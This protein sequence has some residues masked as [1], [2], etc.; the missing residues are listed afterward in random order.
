MITIARISSVVVG[1]V[2]YAFLSATFFEFRGGWI[3]L[4]GAFIAFFLVRLFLLSSTGYKHAAMMVSLGRGVSVM[5]GITAL[6]IQYQLKKNWLYFI[7]TGLLVMLVVRFA[8]AGLEG[9]SLRRSLKEE[10]RGTIDVTLEEVLTQTE[11]KP[12]PQRTPGGGQEPPPPPEATTIEAP[13]PNTHPNG[14]IPTGSS[15]RFPDFT[16]VGRVNVG[17]VIAI[18][19]D[20]SLVVQTPDGNHHDIPKTAAQVETLAPLPP[21]PRSATEIQRTEGIGAVEAIR[22]AKAERDAYQQQTGVVS[23]DNPVDDH[24]AMANDPR[25]PLEIQQELDG[26]VPPPAPVD[27]NAP[28]PRPL[29]AIEQAAG[30]VAAPTPAQAAAGNHRMGHIR[31]GG[32]AATIKMPLGSERT[33]VSADGTPWS[34]T[35]GADYGYIRGTKGAAGDHVHA[36]FGPEAARANPPPVWML[37]QIEPASG[38]FDEHKAMIGFPNR[39]AALTAYHA[40]FSDGSAA[41][42][43]GAIT[44][45]PWQ[46]FRAWVASGN[47]KQPVAY[48]PPPS[49]DQ[50]AAAQGAADTERHKQA[51]TAI[52][53]VLATQN[54]L[55]LTRAQVNEAAVEH[56]AG[57]TPAEAILKVAHRHMIKA[58]VNAGAT[59]HVEQP[60]TESTADQTGPQPGG[61]PGRPA[62]GPGTGHQPNPL[63]PDPSLG[64]SEFAPDVQPD[65]RIVRVEVPTLLKPAPEAHGVGGEPPITPTTQTIETPRSGSYRQ[66]AIPVGS[67][68]M[69]Y[70]FTQASEFAPGTVVGIKDDWLIVDQGD[71]EQHEVPLSPYT[72][73]VIQLAPSPPPP[74]SATTIM[75]DDGIGGLWA[76][77]KA[78]TERDAYTAATGVVIPDNAVDDAKAMLNDP[79]TEA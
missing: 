11:T 71:G 32:L 18:A 23:P 20:G 43:I 24:E 16:Q 31:V 51:L 58:I 10:M 57:L 37:D 25:S 41:S 30:N 47:T 74:R 52:A 15:V 35:M 14:V 77:Q 21:P 70:D 50:Q 13:A 72:V 2:V 39:N 33:G 73:Q 1:G 27:P 66:G 44:A 22:R 5:C 45:M 48:V 9:W 67:K 60:R 61:Q 29:T 4:A 69:M 19:A 34:S 7:G 76:V 42:R 38:L 12:A 3:T 49:V 46:Q 40:S 64:P 68:V 62:G 78:K 63:A 75:R 56:L 17:N 26:I 79:C 59:P 28:P 55:D 65:D 36:Y 6:L 8:W 53:S 54:Q